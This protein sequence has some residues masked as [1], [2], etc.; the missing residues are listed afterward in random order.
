MGGG[1]R[2][3][4]EKERVGGGGRRKGEEGGGGRE[5]G[6]GSGEEEE[7]EERTGGGRGTGLLRNSIPVCS[8]SINLPQLANTQDFIVSMWAHT[9][10]VPD[11]DTQ[12]LLGDNMRP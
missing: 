6:G 10:G 7:E 11:H 8:Y 2:R 12:P 9:Q 5:N 1:R 4:K 3:R